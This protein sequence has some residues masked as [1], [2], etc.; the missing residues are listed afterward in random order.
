VDASAIAARAKL[1]GALA[2]QDAGALA[3][4]RARGYSDD[5]IAALAAERRS[6]GGGLSTI[7]EPIERA[8]VRVVAGFATPADLW[9]LA[10]AQLEQQRIARNARQGRHSA[11]RLRVATMADLHHDSE[12]AIGADIT[13]EQ[14]VNRIQSGQAPRR[15]AL[16]ALVRKTGPGANVPLQVVSAEAAAIGALAAELSAR[17]ISEWLRDD[18]PEIP[19][20]IGRAK[21]KKGSHP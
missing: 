21:K 2:N 3:Y 17:T 8:A 4:L 5:R 11:L 19:A 16:A 10:T 1:L 20:P 6:P 9:D 7:I 12:Y 15:D 18:C 13:R 14:V